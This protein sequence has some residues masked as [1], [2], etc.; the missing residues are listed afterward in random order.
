MTRL[1][2]YVWEVWKDN[3]RREEERKDMRGE[4]VIIHFL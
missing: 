3:N 2:C 4:E 1:S